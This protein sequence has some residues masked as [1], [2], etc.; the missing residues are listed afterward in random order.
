MVLLPVGTLNGTYKKRE[1][2]QNVKKK[3]QDINKKRLEL[4]LITTGLRVA[5]CAHL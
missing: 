2:F 1:F 4:K 3:K 5:S